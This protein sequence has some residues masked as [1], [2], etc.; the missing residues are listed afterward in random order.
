M[1]VLVKWVS[2]ISATSILLSCSVAS[3]SFL[4]LLSPFAFH[5]S[6]RRELEVYELG[7]LLGGEKFSY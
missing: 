1:E 6:M 2:E 4:C 3:N 5:V 7:I